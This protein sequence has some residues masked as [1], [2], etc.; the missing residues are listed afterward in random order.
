MAW[1]REAVRVRRLFMFGVAALL[2]L[3]GCQD[4]RQPPPP[5]DVPAAAYL[6]PEAEVERLRHL[7]RTDPA[8]FA[9]AMADLYGRHR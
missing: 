6:I 3:S 1:R 9:E 7:Q 5:V 8:A 4:A 2:V